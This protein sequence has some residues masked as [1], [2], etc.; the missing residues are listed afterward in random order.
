MAAS[1]PS[2]GSAPRLNPFLFPS[3][4][5]FRFV[6]LIVSVLGSSMFTFNQLY[7]R[8][9]GEDTRQAMLRCSDA[10]PLDASLAL[11]DAQVQCLE[12]LDR[13]Q[14]AW[15]LSGAASVLLV[16]TLIYAVTPALKI[17]RGRLKRLSAR[18]A[19]EVVAYLNGWE[20][21]R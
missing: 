16:A 2:T 21:F 11:F 6:L 13:R 3:D 12:P 5:D 8:V 4:T 20:P 17:R 7:I 15:H 19:P 1:Q 10:Y 14:A 9:L 18:D